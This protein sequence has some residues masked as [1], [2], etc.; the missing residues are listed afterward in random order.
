MVIFSRY[1]W[2]VATMIG[3][4]LFLT[5]AGQ[6]GFLG[7]FQNLFL[8]AATPVEKTMDG[9]FR[10]VASFLSD[11]GDLRSL[12]E[13]NR[14]LRLENEKLQN[15]V[16]ELELDA[17]RVQELE[18]ALEITQSDTSQQ[19][20][21]ANVVSHDSSPFT[22][23][24]SIDRGSNAGIQPGMNVLSSQGSLIGTVTKVTPDH[25]F[26]RLITDSKSKVNAKVRDTQVEGIVKGGPNR[27]VTFD[28]AQADIKV[29]DVIVTSG[30]GGNYQA[31]IPIGR[32]TE[33]KGT[34]QDLFA[35]VTLEPLVRLSTVQTVLVLTSFVPQRLDLD[36]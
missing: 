23:V 10:P 33:V 30:L 15:R 12:Q 36:D 11:F 13:E 1:S 18:K 5:A 34:P 16:T 9:V 24:I 22:D 25:S 27:T 29:G 3:L 28:L 26:I 17:A 8:Q 32:V 19:K 20:V 6:L 14:Q 2:W 35:E 4:A 31:G 21:A 7:P